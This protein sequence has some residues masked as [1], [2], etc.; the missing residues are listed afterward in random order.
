MYNRIQSSMCGGYTTLCTIGY[1]PVCV[2]VI[3]HYVQCST[4]IC[5]AFCLACRLVAWV[6]LSD[7]SVGR[8]ERE[9]GEVEIGRVGGEGGGRDRG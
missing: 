7:S 6:T 2:E 3:L 8:G 5:A 4:F 9:V 1:S